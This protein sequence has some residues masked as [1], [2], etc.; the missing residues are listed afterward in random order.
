M[1]QKKSNTK[2]TSGRITKEDALLLFNALNQEGVSEDAYIGI[3][4]YVDDV[5]TSTLLSDYARNE[6]LFM[7]YFPEGWKDTE[8]HSRRTIARIIQR[9][10]AGET[11]EEIHNAFE[12]YRAAREAKRAVK[13]K[14]QHESIVTARAILEFFD[15]SDVPEFLSDG[16]MILLS[17]AAHAL[18]LP[19]IFMHEEDTNETEA[20]KVAA[21]VTKAG[22]L[23]DVSDA[24]AA[25]GYSD[26][27]EEERGEV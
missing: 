1:S 25:A 17:G 11:I 26:T 3:S 15:R 7:R 9:L 18:N 10:K 19:D 4:Q 27:S 2:K 22:N 21:I 5:V 12:R 8:Q 23:F 20:P 14:Q 24:L 13:D 16:V 6:E